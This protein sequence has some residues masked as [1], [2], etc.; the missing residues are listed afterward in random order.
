M[1]MRHNLRLRHPAFS[2]GAVFLC[3]L[4]QQTTTAA[5]ACIM[6][7]GMMGS[8]MTMP[9]AATDSPMAVPHSMRG[10]ETDRLRCLMHCAQLASAPSDAHQITVPPYVSVALPLT[11]G[12]LPTPPMNRAHDKVMRYWL[13]A[14]PPSAILIFCSLL[15]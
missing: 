13:R 12:L 9:T 2:M 11:A 10:S 8:V 4:L 7:P 14:P 6:A 15:L 5:H 3:L 1:V